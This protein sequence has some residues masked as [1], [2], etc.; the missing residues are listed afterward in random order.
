MTILA[1]KTMALQL[2]H[3]AGSDRFEGV[4]SFVGEDASGS[5]GLL[6]GH[7]RMMTALTAGIVRF[8]VGDNQWHYLVLPGGILYGIGTAVSLC[9]RRYLH[10]TDFRQMGALLAE[11]Q[12]ADAEALGGIKESLQRLEQEIVRRLRDIEQVRYD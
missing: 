2:Y 12:R 10:H 1:T 6:P 11:L 8:R 9:T 3:S 5:F 7:G 4:T